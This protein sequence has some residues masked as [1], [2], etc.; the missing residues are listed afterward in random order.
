MS[1]W[2]PFHDNLDDSNAN[3]IKPANRGLCRLSNMYGRAEGYVANIEAEIMSS[4]D[5]L[6]KIVD[7]IHKRDAMSVASIVFSELTKI[8]N[9]ESYS[10]E[11]LSDF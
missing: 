7:R 11:T 2:F 5:T 3:K 1:R 8:H 10:R 4:D 9:T 6:Q